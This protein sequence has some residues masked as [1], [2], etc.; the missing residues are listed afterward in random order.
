M[1]NITV[2]LLSICMLL[3]AQ[4][5]MASGNTTRATLNRIWQKEQARQERMDKDL[6]N[7]GKNSQG[8]ERGF[9]APY[10]TYRWNQP[11]KT[12]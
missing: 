7:I 2:M 10:G 4:L 9:S 5:A 1:K 3:S 11:S 6:S 12:R 8:A